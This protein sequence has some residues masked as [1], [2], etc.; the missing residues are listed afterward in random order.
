MGMFIAWWFNDGTK[1]AGDAAKKSALETVM[2]TYRRAYAEMNT[3][4]KGGLADPIAVRGPFVNRET[5]VFFGT[6]RI[7]SGAFGKWGIRE[8]PES[9]ITKGG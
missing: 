8:K 1:R 4:S 9:P 2:N 3:Q 5:V 6:L 7:R